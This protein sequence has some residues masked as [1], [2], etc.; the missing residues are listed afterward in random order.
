MPRP[1]W[2]FPT[3]F[4]FPATPGSGTVLQRPPRSQTTHWGCQNLRLSRPRCLRPEELLAAAAE[5]WCQQ[6]A[7]G[8]QAPAPGLGLRPCPETRSSA[9]V[10]SCKRCT[11]GPVPHC[12]TSFLV[13][14][15]LGSTSCFLSSLHTCCYGLQSSFARQTPM[16]TPLLLYRL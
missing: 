14:A 13:A 12:C 1:Q 15:S 7:L 4:T 10:Y 5:R 16:L 6:R 8:L 2:R 9:A 3:A 11:C